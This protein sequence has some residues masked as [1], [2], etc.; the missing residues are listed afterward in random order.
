MTFVLQLRIS[1]SPKLPGGLEYAVG[2]RVRQMGSTGRLWASHAAL[3]AKGNQFLLARDLE[4][5]PERD[6]EYLQLSKC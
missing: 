3:Q 2:E 6:F 4:Q 1:W 5:T